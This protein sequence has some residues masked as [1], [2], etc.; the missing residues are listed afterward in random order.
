MAY[1]RKDH[2]YRRAKEEGKAS[3][4][5]YKLTQINER[6]H[7]VKKGDRVVDLGAAPGGWMQEAAAIVGPAGRVVG[8]DL[9]P[10]KI[11]LPRQVVFLQEKL[12]GEA[13]DQGSRIKKL[14]GG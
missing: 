10:M 1:D 8:I 3:R 14:L 2:Y 4:A 11:S 9:L 7:L 6:F 12:E 13:Q 5:A